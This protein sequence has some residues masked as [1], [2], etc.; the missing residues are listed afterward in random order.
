MAN[1]KKPEDFRKMTYEAFENVVRPYCHGYINYEKRSLKRFWMVS[2]FSI[3]LIISLSDFI[4]KSGL[5]DLE[6]RFTL[7]RIDV[8]SN[9]QANKLTFFY[10]KE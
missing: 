3:C 9:I 10:A 5:S 6:N 8:Y 7:V 2:S 1:D 4:C